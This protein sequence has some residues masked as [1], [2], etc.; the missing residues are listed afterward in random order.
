MEIYGLYC[1]YIFLCHFFLPTTWEVKCD[2]FYSHFRFIKWCREFE[3]LAQV[4]W[5]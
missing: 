5:A 2:S 1:H 4:C 3:Q